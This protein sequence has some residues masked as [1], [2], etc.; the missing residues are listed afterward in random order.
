MSAGD[1]LGGGSL[2]AGLGARWG[3]CAQCERWRVS[4]AWED[5]GTPARCPV[6]GTV[7]DPLEC[8]VGTVGTTVLRL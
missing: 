1:D 8:V 3:Y 6:C 5:A 2:G 7:P 4:D